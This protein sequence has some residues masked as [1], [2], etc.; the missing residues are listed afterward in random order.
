[1]ETEIAAVEQQILDVIMGN[2]PAE[3]VT[4]SQ[5][6][7]ALLAATKQPPPQT[8]TQQKERRKT[9]R[10]KEKQER[11]AQEQK[12]REKKENE[13]RER[14]EKRRRERNEKKQERRSRHLSMD[15]LSVNRLWRRTP[16]LG[17]QGSMNP[18]EAKDFAK[19][20]E[21]YVF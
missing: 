8:E 5:S 9:E 11:E 19:F 3:N 20:S 17:V 10:E 6:T 1:M 12:E 16:N 15:A 4:L 14:E 18:D 7:L 2:T 13:K 21:M